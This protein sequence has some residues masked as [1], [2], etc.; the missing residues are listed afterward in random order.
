LRR[1]CCWSRIGSNRLKSQ[2][3]SNMQPI[4][5][6][7]VRQLNRVAALADKAA[8][9][10]PAM[11]AHSVDYERRQ[12]ELDRETRHELRELRERLAGME[13]WT[14]DESERRAERASP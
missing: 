8:S 13:I 5:R 9:G 1:R 2:F 6:E 10:P 12:R 7:L 4:D 3:R 14:A 11:P